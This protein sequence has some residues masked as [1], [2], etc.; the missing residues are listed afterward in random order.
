ME[1]KTN[2]NKETKCCDQR[3]TGLLQKEKNALFLN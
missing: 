3:G 1:R 2:E